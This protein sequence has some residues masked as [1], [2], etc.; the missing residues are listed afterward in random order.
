MIF[1]S[2]AIVGE[3]FPHAAF[4]PMTVDEWGKQ[5]YKQADH[6]LE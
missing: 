3:R 2:I 5:I 1:R 6:H 4:G